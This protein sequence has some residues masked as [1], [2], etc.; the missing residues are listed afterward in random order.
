M[1]LTIRSDPLVGRQVAT[2]VA[3][4]L[5]VKGRDLNSAGGDQSKTD[6][7]RRVRSSTAAVG[8]ADSRPLSTSSAVGL[9]SPCRWAGAQADSCR[10]VS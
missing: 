6:S 2:S 5:E 3:I 8:R 4:V 7:C 1:L 9:L 10:Y